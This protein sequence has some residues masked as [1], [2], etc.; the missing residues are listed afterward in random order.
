MKE[1]TLFG[2]NSEDLRHINEKMAE[3]GKVL[4]TLIDLK[5]EE[6]VNNRLRLKHSDGGG[7]RIMN[8][9]FPKI[10]AKIKVALMIEDIRQK[11]R[12]LEQKTKWNWSKREE[13]NARCRV[14]KEFSLGEV[15]AEEKRIVREKIHQNGKLE[16]VEREEKVPANLPFVQFSIQDTLTK[17]G[18]A[19]AAVMGGHLAGM[20]IHYQTLTMDLEIA[21]YM[22]ALTV[23]LTFIVTYVIPFLHINYVL[24]SPVRKHYAE[25]Y[26]MLTYMKDFFFER[27]IQDYNAL[28][29][30]DKKNIVQMSVYGDMLQKYINREPPEVIDP[31]DINPKKMKVRVTMDKIHRVEDPM[32]KL[33]P[34][35]PE[36]EK[37]SLATLD[38]D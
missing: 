12:V 10:P 1:S 14:E 15:I 31:H 19:V 34:S 32:A 6:F 35:L 38:F 3:K 22:S 4:P 30:D 8:S 28:S 27:A 25:L 23:L 37:R 24:N 26:K 18:I 13:E 29:R 11:M 20:G 16:H 33:R 36:V 5:L 7:F 21:A 9:Y 17:T 2:A